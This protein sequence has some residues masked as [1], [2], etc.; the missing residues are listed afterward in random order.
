[1]NIRTIHVFSIEIPFK[2]LEYLKV[3]ENLK[4]L[5]ETFLER[6]AFCGSSGISISYEPF[7]RQAPLNKFI[8]VTSI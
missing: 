1:M 2:F 8:V 7:R 4:G 3:S 5:F 6:K